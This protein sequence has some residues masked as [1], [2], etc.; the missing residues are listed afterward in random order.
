M[1]GE[2]IPLKWGPG[3][4]GPGNNLFFF[5]HDTDGNWVEISAELE[6]VKPDRAVGAWPHEER[7]LNRWGI[8]LLRS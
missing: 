2:R 7:T 3:R 8:G 5:I 6:V 4:H 1:A